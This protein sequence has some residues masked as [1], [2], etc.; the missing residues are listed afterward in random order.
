MN[1]KTIAVERVMVISPGP[2]EPVV[3]AIKAAVGHPDLGEFGRA[4]RSAGTFAELEA[5][6][7]R[8]LGK[9]G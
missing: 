2:F 1:T 6:V 4:T 9:R 5:S 8:G 3:A 7:E